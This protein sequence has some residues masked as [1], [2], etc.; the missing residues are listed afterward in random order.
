MRRTSITER[1]PRLAAY[2]ADV[3]AVTFIATAAVIAFTAVVEHYRPGTAA[4]YLPPQGLLTLAAASGVASL[5]APVKAVR[6][7]TQ[8]VLHAAAGL[9]TLALVTHVAWRYFAALGA[10]R[11]PLTAAAAFITVSAFAGMQR[12]AENGEEM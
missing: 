1:H 7:R 10:A 3:G 9:L 5:A 8:H 2:V 6:S 12:V 4:S 11:L